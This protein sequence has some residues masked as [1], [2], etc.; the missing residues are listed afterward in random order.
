MANYMPR[1]V[2]PAL[3]LC[4]TA[5]RPAKRWRLALAGEVCYEDEL[6][7]AG[8]ASLMARL[9]A[10]AD[11]VGSVMVVAHNPGCTTLPSHAR[12]RQGGCLS[13]SADKLRP[14]LSLSFRSRAY[15]R[16]R[17]GWG[18]AGRVGLPPRT[19]T[20]ELET[21]LADLGFKVMDRAHRRSSA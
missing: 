2:E 19:L 15:G 11:D 13:P 20:H 9:H 7:G 4:S 6:Y 12:G 1:A 3:V 10:V 18:G 21:F 8:A 5:L 17:A 14:A 16:P